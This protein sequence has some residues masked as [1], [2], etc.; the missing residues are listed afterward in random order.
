MQ[1]TEQSFDLILAGDVFIYI[2]DLSQSF[3]ACAQSLTPGGILAITT[4]QGLPEQDY[5][6]DPKRVAMPTAPAI[7]ANWGPVMD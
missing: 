3:A 6:W 4:E 1:R 7:C 5:T 2:G